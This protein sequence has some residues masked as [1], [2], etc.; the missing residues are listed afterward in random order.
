MT[1][2]LSQT[3]PPAEAGFEPAALAEAIAF[4]EAHDSPFPHDIRAHLEAGYFE[5]APDNAV[6]GS[7]WPRGGPNGLLLRHGRLV[8]QW[9]DTKRADMTFS[10][11]KSYLALLAGL[12]V[13]DGLI[14]DLDARVSASVADPAFTGPRNGAITWRMLLD[15]TSE[16]EG[17]L[18]G[19]A[20]RIDRGRDLRREGSGPK[21]IDRPLAA[22]GEHW[23]Y[24]DVRVNALALALLHRFRRPLP[25]VFAERIMTPIGGSRDWRWEGYSTSFVQIDGQRIQSVSGGGHWGGGV[26]MHAE[27]QALIG[28]L[29]ARDGVW[30]GQRILP[31]GC[32][33]ACTTPSRLNKNYGLLWWLNGQG[34]HPGASLESFFAQGAGGNT[35]WIDPANDIVGVFRWLDP[36]ARPEAL[37]RITKALR[38]IAGSRG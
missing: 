16:W 4:V 19:K 36:E 20:D 17:T 34:S 28:L 26:V 37:A 31:E 9:G 14:A 5:P 30:N 22:P 2:A 24:N 29:M 33:A 32:V 12:A 18:F 1:S 10:V 15:Q 8:A 25:E 11:A 6:L 23:E 3:L 13:G 35:I 7:V 21:G 27:D 38:P